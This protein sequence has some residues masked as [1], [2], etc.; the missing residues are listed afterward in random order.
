MQIREQ[1]N[2]FLKHVAAFVCMYALLHLIYF[3]G[4]GYGA[5]YNSMVLM[6]SVSIVSGIGAAIVSQR[7]CK[8]QESFRIC[9]RQICTVF[10][11]FLTIS[12]LLFHGAPYQGWLEKIYYYFPQLIILVYMIPGEICY[13]LSIGAHLLKRKENILLKNIS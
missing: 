3:Y 2:G 13:A 10:G 6:L 5:G 7:I 4:G 12:A 1:L 11:L 8:K 9:L